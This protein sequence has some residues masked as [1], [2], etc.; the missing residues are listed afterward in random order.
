MPAMDDNLFDL[1]AGSRRL[2]L[3]YPP[4]NTISYIL[5]L[6]RQF[7]GRLDI[8]DDQHGHTRFYL[9]FKL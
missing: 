4:V 5:P 3:S 1:L 8:S 6:L 7:N 9:S 2:A